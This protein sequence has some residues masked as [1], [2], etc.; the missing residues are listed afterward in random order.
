[1]NVSHCLLLEVVIFILPALP[2]Y[3]LPRQQLSVY[4]GVLKAA[5]GQ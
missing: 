1:M 3:L 4:F 5:L 2:L